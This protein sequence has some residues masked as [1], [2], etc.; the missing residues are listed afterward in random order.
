MLPPGEYKR[1]AIP[2]FAKLLWSLFAIGI[3]NECCKLYVFG[4]GEH[5]GG[6]ERR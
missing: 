1:G 6:Q 5:F 3:Q 4:V 2:P